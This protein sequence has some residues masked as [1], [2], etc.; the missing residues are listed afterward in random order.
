MATAARSN[1]AA[2]LSEYP[3]L[4]FADDAS[5]AQ[6]GRWDDVFHRRV[7]PRFG[8]RLVFEVGCNDADLLA[9]V[10]ARHPNVA[11]VGLDWKYK[12]I[13]DAARRVTAAGLRNVALL[14]ARA[15][16][17][18]RI[19]GGAEVDEVW[20]FHPDPC[21][22]PKEL[23][24]RLIA[25]PFLLDVARVLRSPGATLTLK[26]DHPGYFQSTLALL[27]LP[28]PPHF[29]AAL[30][31]EPAS[32]R[33]RPRDLMCPAALPPAS[34]TVLAAFDPAVRSCD[35]WSDPVA[36]T[37]LAGRLFGHERTTFEARFARKRRPIHYIELRKR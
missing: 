14:R 36:V 27:G 16:D 26:T 17:V 13:Y 33:V 18:A 15:E 5:L 34:P 37:H 24:N 19:F 6:R 22:K 28:Q 32:P 35:L 21:D 30:A 2:R 31:G 10:A 11:F 23:P 12:A 7:G 3:S 20:V 25:E 29:A 4:V 9:R 1:H 8:G